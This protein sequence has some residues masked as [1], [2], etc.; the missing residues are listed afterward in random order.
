MRLPRRLSMKNFANFAQ[1]KER[2]NTESKS[3]LNPYTKY[4]AFY[5]SLTNSS[6][7]LRIRYGAFYK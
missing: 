6:L 1:Y 4:K 7:F 5:N 2:I 3:L